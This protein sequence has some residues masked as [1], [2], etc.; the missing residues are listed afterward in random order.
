M[1]F[2]LTFHESFLLTT[3][4]SAKRSILNANG[5][6][7]LSGN[8]FVGWRNGQPA[9]DPFAQPTAKT[10]L[11]GSIE[12]LSVGMNSLSAGFSIRPMIGIGAFGFNTGVYVGLDFSGSVLKQSDIVLAA[13]RGGYMNGQID[14]GVGYQLSTGLVHL[15]NGLLSAFTSYQVPDSGNADSRS[16][17]DFMQLNTDI[18]K[19]CSGVKT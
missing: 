19:G 18:P 4:F 3:G 10:D 14:S 17:P 11:G 5:E 9:F 1:P 2:Q 15:I 13:C 6:Y 8:L 7:T 12:G 16:E